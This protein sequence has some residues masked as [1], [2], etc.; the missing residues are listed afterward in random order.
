V[1]I[2]P[3]PTLQIILARIFSLN[4]LCIQDLHICLLV[5]SGSLSASLHY[6]LIPSTHHTCFTSPCLLRSLPTPTYSLLTLDLRRL[7]RIANVSPPP[8]PFSARFEL[9]SPK[10][11]LQLSCRLYSP[12]VH[13]S[14]F[15][16]PTS[17]PAL[18]MW[19]DDVSVVKATPLS[20]SMNRPPQ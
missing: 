19:V 18:R 20:S 6:H 10:T 2:S 12:R 13:A 9:L 17:L 8:Q 3:L 5:V 14:R 16:T 1:K 15:P 11:S 7:M 4:Y